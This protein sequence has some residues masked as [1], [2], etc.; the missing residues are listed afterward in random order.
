MKLWLHSTRW[1]LYRHFTPSGLCE[2]RAARRYWRDQDKALTAFL[3]SDRYAQIKACKH[4]NRRPNPDATG[5][6]ASGWI[7][8]ICN[9]CGIGYSKR[10]KK[11]DLWNTPTTSSGKFEE[12]KRSG[13]IFYGV[14]R[15]D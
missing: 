13:D 9:D 10:P 3:A 8:E 6:I 12:A 5:A 7:P 15:E 1:W 14:K 11:I 4:E 2:L